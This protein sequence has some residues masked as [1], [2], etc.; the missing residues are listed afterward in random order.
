MES[1]DRKNRYASPLQI[2]PQPFHLDPEKNRLPG[3]FFRAP[4]SLSIGPAT[5]GLTHFTI[6]DHNQ[7]A[8]SLDI[9]HLPNTFLS[10]EVTTY[11]PEDRCKL[12]ILVYRID[13]AIHREIQ[14]LRENVF[15]LVP[16]LRSRGIFHV[17]AHPFFGVNDRLNPSHFERCLLLF[18][19]FELNGARD[20]QLNILL[21]ELLSRLR[22]KDLEK[23]A[24]RHNLAPCGDQPWKKHLTGGSDD[25]STLSLGRQY[26][27]CPAPGR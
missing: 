1:P 17:L 10:E 18:N 19:Y 15:E 25:H 6:T 12:H 5:Q 16:F 20:G 23:L 24:D 13:E 4:P 14:S 3:K 8:G 21:R 7:L 27:R 22:G 26:R 2:L 9:A 11:F